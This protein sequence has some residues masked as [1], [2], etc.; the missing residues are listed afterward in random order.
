MAPFFARGHMEHILKTIETLETKITEHERAILKLRS[1]INDLCVAANM[2]AKYQ[3]NGDVGDSPSPVKLLGAI[4][5]DQFY[6]KPQ[7]TAVR[8]ALNMLR[9][10]GRA[11]ATVDAIYDVL[12]AGGFAF[13][14][15]AR[16]ASI[17]GLTVSIGKNSAIFVKL[18]NGLIG[19]TDW[20]GGPRAR[21]RPRTS[22]NGDQG[23]Q[24][25]T[26]IPDE[27]ERQEGGTS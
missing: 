21:Q 2:P 8:D 11:P 6:G 15:K 26:E 1:T 17:Q 16:E 3:L 14:T 5:P 23:E 18:P 24:A 12:I 25:E 10:A 4:K 20:Y 13:P 9:A 19:V 27:P 7:A 22:A